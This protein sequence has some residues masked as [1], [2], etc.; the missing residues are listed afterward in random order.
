MSSF[1][2]FMWLEQLDAQTSRQ[3]ALIPFLPSDQAH[4]TH[5]VSSPKMCISNQLMEHIPCTIRILR[6]GS[7]AQAEFMGL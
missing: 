1:K 4:S 2:L 6:S 3:L 7:K 5:I